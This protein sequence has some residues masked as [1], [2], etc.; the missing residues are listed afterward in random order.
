MD[1]LDLLRSVKPGRDASSNLAT[2]SRRRSETR[3]EVGPTTEQKLRFVV[4]GN[5]K[6]VVEFHRQLQSTETQKHLEE[7]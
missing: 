5:K 2:A 6:R 7:S 1:K 4:A 3:A